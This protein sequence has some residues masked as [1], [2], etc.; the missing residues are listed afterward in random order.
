MA[1]ELINGLIERQIKASSVYQKGL[2]DERTRCLEILR[3]MFGDDAE[4]CVELIKSGRGPGETHEP[5]SNGSSRRV[6][7]AHT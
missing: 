6:S 2:M 1:D 4:A 5:G 7:K 3:Y